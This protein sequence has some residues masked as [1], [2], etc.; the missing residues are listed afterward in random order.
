VPSSLLLLL[1][2]KMLAAAPPS[3]A[4]GCNCAA[5]G[6]TA[7]MQCWQQTHCVQ[8]KAQAGTSASTSS[9]NMCCWHAMPALTP[10]VKS[11]CKFSS[12]NHAVEYR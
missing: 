1:L 2:L 5:Q 12:H 7:R 10:L 9:G 11:T 8:N 6:P 3:L 4:G